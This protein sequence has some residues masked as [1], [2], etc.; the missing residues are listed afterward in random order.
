MRVK[1]YLFSMEL[2]SKTKPTRVGVSEFT[3]IFNAVCGTNFVRMFIVTF[4]LMFTIASSYMIILL[5]VNIEQTIKRSCSP[6]RRVNARRKH[7]ANLPAG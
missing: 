4:F 2:A 7:L 3:L 5:K 1:A 6:H